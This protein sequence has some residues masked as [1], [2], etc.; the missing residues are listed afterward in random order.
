[1]P[2]SIFFGTV[3]R[4]MRCGIRRRPWGL[5][6]R[7]QRQ[8]ARR[9]RNVE[10]REFSDAFGRYRVQKRISLGGFGEVSWPWIP[11]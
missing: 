10:G 9:R 2:R 8:A 11:S 1:M 6:E 3:S 5:P 4:G 7:P